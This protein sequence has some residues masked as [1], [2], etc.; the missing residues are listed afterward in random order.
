MTQLTQY[1]IRNLIESLR[2]SFRSWQL[3][4]RVGQIESVIGAI[5]SAA[6]ERYAGALAIYP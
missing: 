3:P 1:L 6:S 5:G 4:W 2:K